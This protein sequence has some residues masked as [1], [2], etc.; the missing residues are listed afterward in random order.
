[1]PTVR[2]NSFKNMEIN[3]LLGPFPRFPVDMSEDV[4]KAEL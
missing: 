1:M 3:S 2:K 4:K